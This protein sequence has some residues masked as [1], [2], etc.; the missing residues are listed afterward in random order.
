MKYLCARVVETNLV[1]NAKYLLRYTLKAVDTW[2]II[3]AFESWLY[4]LFWVIERADVLSK[5]ICKY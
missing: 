4:F 2:R 3:S 5:F 1:M